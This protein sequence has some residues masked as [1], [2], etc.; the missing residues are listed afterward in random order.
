MGRLGYSPKFGCR[1]IH[2]FCFI[3]HLRVGYATNKPFLTSLTPKP[4]Y[5]FGS[6]KIRRVWQ[7]VPDAD[8]LYENLQMQNNI[9]HSAYLTK[10]S[11]KVD[12]FLGSSCIYR[13]LQNNLSRKILY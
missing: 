7:T 10:V 5:V 1:R 2:K 4:D 6:H 9:I 8:F 3:L 11:R 12:V 13:N